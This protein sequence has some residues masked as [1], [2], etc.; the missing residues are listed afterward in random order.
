MEEYYEVYI[1]GKKTLYHVDLASAIEEVSKMT[2]IS[3]EDIKNEC[4]KEE[5]VQMHFKKDNEQYDIF[6][7]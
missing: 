6:R 5:F 2:N 1:D 3:I 7:S 4:D